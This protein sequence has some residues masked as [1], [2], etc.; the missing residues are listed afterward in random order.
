MSD[1][2]EQEFDPSRR[3]LC[4]DGSCVGVIGDNGRCR[5]CGASD[6]GW[7]GEPSLAT[8]MEKAPAE[9][10]EVAGD[11]ECDPDGSGFAPSRRLCSD[12]TCMGVLGPNGRCSICGQVG[13]PGE[14]GPAAA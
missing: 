7:T 1:F 6:P 8:P 2:A 10:G 9:S 12:G 14:S 4:P 13:D 11:R 5:E 3:R